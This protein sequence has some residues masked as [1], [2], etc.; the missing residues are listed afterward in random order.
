M[1]HEAKDEKSAK[2]L[3]E[4]GLCAN[5]GVRRVLSSGGMLTQIVSRTGQKRYTYE[6]YSVLTKEEKRQGLNIDFNTA[7]FFISTEKEAQAKRV[8][9]SYDNSPIKMA[10]V[11]ALIMILF[12]C[13]S[14]FM[15]A[16]LSFLNGIIA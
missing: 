16:L 8:Y 15:P 13:V 11:C 3:K 12:V 14:L 9:E 7:A 10:L 6:E 1:R 5:K 4:L 2:T